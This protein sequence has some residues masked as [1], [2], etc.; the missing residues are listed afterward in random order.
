ME[1]IDRRGHRSR[2]DRGGAR[3]LLSGGRPHPHGAV[4]AALG[5][6][7]E[8][9]Y[10]IVLKVGS[11]AEVFERNIGKDSPLKIKRGINASWK[12]GGLHYA[13]PIR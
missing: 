8:W 11:Y 4:G 1:Q 5:L 2:G 7:N 13:P 9:A 6:P 10:N 3:R 12:D